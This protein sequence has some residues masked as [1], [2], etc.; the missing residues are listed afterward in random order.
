MVFVP[1]TRPPYPEEFRREALEWLRA[2]RSPREVADSLGVSEQTLRNWRRQDQLDR[3]ERDNGLTP[4]SGVSWPSCARRSVAWSR[5]AI[6]SSEPRPS[7]PG[8]PRPGDR[9]PDDLGGEGRGVPGLR[10]LWPAWRDPLGL[11]RLGA[12]SP[13]GPRSDR[14]VAD[15]EDQ[16]HPR[17]EPRRLRIAAH[18][19]RSAPGARRASVG[20]ARAAPDAQRRHLGAGAPHARAHHDPRAG[21][22]GRRR[23]RRAP[24]PTGGPERA[25][26]GRRDLPAH[27]GGLA[28]PGRR[29]GRLQPPDRRL[30]HGRPHAHRARRRRA[31]DGHRSP[32]AAARPCSP[33]RSGKYVSLGFGQKARDAG[34]AVSMGSVA[35]AATTP[36]PRCSSRRSRRSS[37]TAAP[38]PRAA[39]WPARSS[40]TSRRS[41]TAG[42]AT[43][44]SATSHPP[45]TR[46]CQIS[47]GHPRLAFAFAWERNC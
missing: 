17:R 11:L 5:S 44:R 8:R 16:D 25:V 46:R 47:P 37:S 4:M 41:T 10:C 27:L 45:T 28:V 13:V 23:P 35:T 32:P 43:R 19:R 14:R 26:G 22:Q 7:S 29:P 40:S 24:V 12:P 36:S 18:P 34:I 1:R 39:S 20:Q 21:R 30:E 38:G 2:G 9:L 3:R 42:A 15:R 31:R 6:C 33:Q